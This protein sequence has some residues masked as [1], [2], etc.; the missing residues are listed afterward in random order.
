MAKVT[1]IDSRH[2]EANGGRNHGR[3]QEEASFHRPAEEN[4]LALVQL[5]E[6]AIGKAGSD[7]QQGS[8]AGIRADKVVTGTFNLTVP[9]TKRTFAPVLRVAGRIYA[10]WYWFAGGGTD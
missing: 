9:G 6:F 7:R 10:P 8:K 5:A 2:Q 4:L 1:A 3:H